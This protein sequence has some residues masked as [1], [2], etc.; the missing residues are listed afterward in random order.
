LC[1]QQTT[2]ASVCLPV[3]EQDRKSTQASVQMKNEACRP[4][5]SKGLCCEKLTTPQNNLQ[6]EPPKNEGGLASIA[7]KAQA[8]V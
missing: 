7:L 1:R 5:S 8:Q 4:G 3:V 2:Q 6:R